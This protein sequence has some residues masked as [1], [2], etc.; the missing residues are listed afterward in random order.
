LRL[1][2]TF[3]HGHIWHC[4]REREECAIHNLLRLSIHLS[5]FQLYKANTHTKKHTWT[6]VQGTQ[7][8][9]EN[10]ARSSVQSSLAMNCDE[11]MINAAP[12]SKNLSV[13]LPVK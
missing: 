1:R 9:N 6:A 7:W 8:L 2:K 3:I 5:P 10:G 4:T 12:R 13:I 11:C